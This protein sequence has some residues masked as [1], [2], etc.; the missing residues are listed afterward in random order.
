SRIWQVVDRH[1]VHT[2]FTAPTA[3]RALMKEGDD[4]VRRTDRSSLKVL[5]SVGEP[6]NPEAWRW[7][8][9]VVGEG[10]APIVDAWWQTETGGIMIAPIPGAVPMKP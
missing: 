10:R 3:L 5:G 7:Y 4:F 2:L 6:I 9:D 1:K 8:H